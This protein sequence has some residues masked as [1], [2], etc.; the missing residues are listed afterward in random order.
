M[1]ISSVVLAF[2]LLMSLYGVNCQLDELFYDLQE[3]RGPVVVIADLST[4]SNVSSVLDSTEMPFLKFQLY[5]GPSRTNFRLNNLTG[6]LSAVERIDREAIC[7]FQITCVIRLNV[8]IQSLKPGS[9]FFHTITVYINIEDINDNSPLFPEVTSNLAIM[10]SAAI[11]STYIID[12]AT[13]LDTGEGNSVQSYSLVPESPVFGIKTQRK[14][15]GS[16]EV[17]L[18]IVA[19]LDRE[20]VSHYD[21]TVMAYDGG[22][23]RKSGEMTLSINVTDVNDNWP[24]FTN[25]VYNASVNETTA[26]NVAFT[27]VSATDADDGPNGQISYRFSSRQTDFAAVRYFGINSENGEIYPT[28]SLSPLQGQTKRIVIEATDSGSDI[29]VSQCIVQVTVLD[30]ANN[31]PTIRINLLNENN[32]VEILES[33]SIGSLVAHFVTSDKDSG[34]N[35]VVS[36]FVSNSSEFSV[37]QIKI[38]QFK[39]VLSQKVDRETQSSHQ[40][41][42][43]CQDG[44]QPPL[45]TTVGLKVMLIDVNDNSPVFENNKIY[46][47]VSENNENGLKL[48]TVRATDVDV[49]ENGAVT[50]RLGRVSPM[51][52][53]IFV[54]QTTGDVIVL[55]SFDYESEKNVNITV[56]A[57]DGGVPPLSS[58][59]TLY[60]SIIDE[61]DNSPY[62]DEPVYIFNIK[63]NLASGQFVGKVKA[64][65]D[66]S[67]VNGRLNY[68]LEQNSSL[69]FSFSNDG[70]L[71]TLK[72]FDREEKATYNFKVIAYDLSDSPK[73]SNVLVTVSILDQNDNIPT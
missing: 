1:N 20:G 14:L 13:D 38:N 66:D 35:G 64:K 37:R 45:Q 58:S 59:E 4:D 60:L 41:S 40:M 3:E 25:T 67:G 18:V 54:N 50:Y 46:L 47:N 2:I 69:P 8:G 26:T 68:M 73:S 39:V 31:P 65:D 29:K 7:R 42:L 56:I 44:G 28:M 24:Q 71:T 52:S 19:E 12:G 43:V 16:I 30:N 27:T 34:Q 5:S 49:E 9:S 11:G 70:D 6:Y 48:T 32:T 10:E 62:F 21:V 72:S 53:T 57:E 36:C 23:P 33:A 63:E 61:N 51:T 55:G 22:N 17:R 15:D